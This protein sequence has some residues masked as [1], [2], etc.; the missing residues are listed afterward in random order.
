MSFLT[1][2]I[3]LNRFIFIFNFSCHDHTTESVLNILFKL[4]ST[5]LTCAPRVECTYLLCRQRTSYFLTS[6]CTLQSQISTSSIPESSSCLCSLSSSRWRSSCRSRLISSSLRA[7]A[8]SLAESAIRSSSISRQRDSRSSR[9]FSYFENIFEWTIRSC[10]Q[11]L[12]LGVL[13]IL[14]LK[15]HSHGAYYMVDFS[16]F[17]LKIC[18]FSKQAAI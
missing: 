17:T 14:G 13:F 4:L 16:V 15:T 9:K 3:Y 6:T 1:N 2:S 11:T 18:L 12:L 10:C 7:A 5:K 8:R